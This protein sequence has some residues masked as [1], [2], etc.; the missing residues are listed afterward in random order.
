MTKDNLKTETANSTN[1]V[2]EAVYPEAKKVAEMLAEL[3]K[4]RDGYK[5][6]SKERMEYN[7]VCDKLYCLASH[8]L[9]G[10]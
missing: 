3:R 9:N 7:G 5:Y 4:Y 8:L 6:G 10:F 1:T 2:L